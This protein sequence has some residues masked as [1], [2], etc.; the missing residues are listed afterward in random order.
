MRKRTKN[1]EHEHRSRA[2][3]IPEFMR[4][5]AARRDD[6]GKYVDE[7]KPEDIA[8]VGEEFLTGDADRERDEKFDAVARTIFDSRY[9]LRLILTEIIRHHPVAVGKRSDEA[10]LDAA[11]N[12]LLGPDT[13]TVQEGHE[14]ETAPDKPRGGRKELA[15]ENLLRIVA[16]EYL[17]DTYGFSEK[18][19]TVTELYRAA[20]YEA[21]RDWRSMSA[22]QIDKIRRRLANKFTDRAARDRIMIEYTG[23]SEYEARRYIDLANRTLPFFRALGLVGPTPSSVDKT[24]R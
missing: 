23:S 21:I 12:A 7:T 9:A 16:R 13:G 6:A 17:R 5:D 11:L 20:I 10:R 14:G 4:A 24:E 18:R 15:D 19:R 3:D 2:A 1:A 8:W 22:D